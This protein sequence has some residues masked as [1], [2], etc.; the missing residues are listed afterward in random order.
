M[1]VLVYFETL[2]LVVVM[3][4]VYI[5]INRK[6]NLLHI[7][8]PGLV[9]FLGN[10]LLFAGDHLHFL[11]VMKQL[12]GKLAILANDM[13]TL[14][15]YPTLDRHGKTFRLHLGLRPNLVVSSSS[16]YEV[17][18]GS[19]LHTCKGRKTTLK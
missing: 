4:Y 3:Y 13:H 8:G 6:Y 19:T 1:P 10:A 16:A 14:V 11:P 7:P 12:I 9:P 18:L 17:I 2:C 15:T 5:I